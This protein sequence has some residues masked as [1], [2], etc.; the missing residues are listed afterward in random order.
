MESQ[1]TVGFSVLSLAVSS[2]PLEIWPT[3]LYNDMESL[4]GFPVISKHV[5]LNQLNDLEWL[6]YVKFC[7]RA[8]K[9][10]TSC[11][12]FKSRR[13]NKKYR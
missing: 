3:L 2:E 5:T 8:C 7:F 9:S 10:R 13:V 12:A 11:V 4:V 6:F 1:T